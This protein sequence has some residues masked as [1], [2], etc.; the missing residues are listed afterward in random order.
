MAWTATVAAPAN[1]QR[2]I[3]LPYPNGLTLQERREFEAAKRAAAVLLAAY[4]PI[5][6]D[7]TEIVLTGNTGTISVVLQQDT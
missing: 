7:D 5:E 1:S 3:E 4:K 2:V 6:D